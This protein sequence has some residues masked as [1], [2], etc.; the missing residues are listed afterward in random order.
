MAAHEATLVQV[1]KLGLDDLAESLA[2]HS[3]DMLLTHAPPWAAAR[4]SDTERGL[5]TGATRHASKG[6]GA[7][8]D[9]MSGMF[10]ARRTRAGMAA[11]QGL[12]AR[13]ARCI[14]RPVMIAHSLC[15]PFGR[16]MRHHRC[17]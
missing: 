6:S 9:L 2:I 15:A 4:L 7:R 10:A 14:D 12:D 11:D 13:Q 3:R 5:G 1:E 8:L 16:S 17:A